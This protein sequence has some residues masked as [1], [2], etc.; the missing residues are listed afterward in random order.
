VHDGTAPVASADRHQPLGF[1]N[2]QRFPQGDQTDVELFDEDFLAWQQIAV[3]QFAIDDLATQLVGYDFGDPWR[4]QSATGVKPI[5]HGGHPI[6]VHSA[7][8]AILAV[9]I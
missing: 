3:G 2:P 5:S 4:R 9:M 7:G 8:L 6:L 1:Q